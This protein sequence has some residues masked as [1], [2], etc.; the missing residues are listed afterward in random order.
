MNPKGYG[1][2]AFELGSHGR[3]EPVTT[4]NT[5]GLNLTAYAVGNGS[6]L[7]VTIINKEHG[8]GARDAAVTILPDGVSSGSAAVMFLTAPNG[9]LGA[10]NGVTLG[11]ASMTNNA[12]W[13]GKWTSLNSVTNGQCTVTVPA[14]SAAVVKVSGR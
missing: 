1:I 7:Y 11:G 13:L 12:P 4:V 9:N 8:A 14:A 2:R 10:T 3:V 6:N 5:N